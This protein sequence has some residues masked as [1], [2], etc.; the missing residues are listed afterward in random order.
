MNLADRTSKDPQKIPIDY[1]PG[2]GPTLT[3]ILKNAGYKTIYRLALASVNDLCQFSDIDETSAQKALNRARSALKIILRP[4]NQRK[5]T[6]LPLKQSQVKIPKP[7]KPKE[8][9]SLFRIFQPKAGPGIPGNYQKVIEWLKHSNYSNLDLFVEFNVPG[10]WQVDLALF[11]SN[12]IWLVEIKNI[13]FSHVYLNAPWTPISHPAKQAYTRKIQG[14]YQ[15]SYQQAIQ[16]A[17]GLKRWLV[18]RPVS[19]FQ[20]TARGDLSNC[21]KVYPSVLIPEKSELLEKQR[22]NWCFL[23]VGTE[24]LATNLQR[25]W[26]DDITLDRSSITRIADELGL[27][28]DYIIQK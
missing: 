23:A 1:L 26:R 5:S 25:S 6:Q 9:H 17:D 10:G 4:F 14:R 24:E 12:G 2:I 20:G 19:Y 28:E 18:N 21:L 16:A 8:T 11:G 27:Q 15:N 3:G 7:E 13:S 22:H